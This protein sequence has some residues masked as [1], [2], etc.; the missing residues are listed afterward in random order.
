MRRQPAGSVVPL[1][2]AQPGRRTQNQLAI[3]S[4]VEVEKAVEL[5]GFHVERPAA[6]P[7]E[8]PVVL[9]EIGRSR[10]AEL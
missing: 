10:F 4:S 9:D 3:L 5:A 6:N 2:Q 1:F 8:V 7:A